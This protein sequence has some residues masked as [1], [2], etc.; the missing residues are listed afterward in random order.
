M[1]LGLWH[2]ASHAAAK[3]RIL[4]PVLLLLAIGP[5]L[6]HHIPLSSLLVPVLEERFAQTLPADGTKIEGIIALGGD[7][8]RV[9]EAVALAHRFPDAKLV[10]A[11]ADEKAQAYARAN[12]IRRTGS[13]SK[14]DHA[15]RTK[16]PCLRRPC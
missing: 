3:R 14:R 10:I 6:A 15:T 11:G 5:A 16:M 13:C 9:V 4:A 12:G 2:L 1:L 7:Q 8:N